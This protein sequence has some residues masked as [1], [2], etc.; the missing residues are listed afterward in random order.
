MPQSY[1]YAYYT[2][3]P[4]YSFDLVFHS[5]LRLPSSQS[6]VNINGNEGKYHDVA[7]FTGER[8]RRDDAYSVINNELASKAVKHYRITKT[9]IKRKP[10]TKSA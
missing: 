9:A 3:N 5:R 7:I 8:E 6:G 10:S 2:L 4:D 1:L